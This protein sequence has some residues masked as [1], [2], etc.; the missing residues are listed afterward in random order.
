MVLKQQIILASV[1]LSMGG[2]FA[3]VFWP[4]LKAEFKEKEIILASIKLENLCSFQDDVFIVVDDASGR[5]SGFRNGV[6]YI[7]VKEGSNVRLALS[8][9]YPNFRYDG[10]PEP[11]KKSM[12]MIADCNASPRMKMIMDSMNKSFSN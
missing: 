11:A 6:A 9:E 7:N 12:T 3:Y 5:S 10:N 8:P 1:I 2:L 4:S